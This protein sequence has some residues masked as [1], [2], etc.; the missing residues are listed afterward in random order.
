MTSASP[1][2]FFAISGQ[3]CILAVPLNP[4]FGSVAQR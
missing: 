1:E 4:V 2:I 3:A